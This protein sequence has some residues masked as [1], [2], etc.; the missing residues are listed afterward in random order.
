[1]TIR[2]L[3][4][5]ALLLLLVAS[6]T[7]SQA[8]TS[9]ER[10]RR[11][12]DGQARPYYRGPFRFTLGAGV[13]YYNG[14]LTSSLG[15]QFLG[16][17]LSAGLLYQ[18]HPHWQVGG[19]ISY[20]KL[21]AKDYLPERGLAFEGKN[22][23]GITFVRWE[24]FHD[25]GAYATPH[26]PAAII[27]PYLKV[28]AGFALYSPKSFRGAARPSG[29]FTPAYLDPERNDYPALALVLPVGVGFTVRLTSQLSAS[30]EGSY[31]LTTTDQLDDISTFKPAGSEQ[32]RSASALRDNYGQLELKL[33]YAPWAR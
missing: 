28:G 33:E 32:S 23:V 31:S 11:H 9:P 18:L 21:G 19:E 2:P 22:G 6:A 10:R 26:A 12:Y 17:S 27:K 4:P 16:P 15:D 25:E 7:S 1:M 5:S 24:P 13:G 8:Q 20:L 14:D 29:N 30:L 3:L